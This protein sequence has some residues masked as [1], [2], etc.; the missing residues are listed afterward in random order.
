MKKDLNRQYAL[1]EVGSWTFD[2]GRS[3]VSILAPFDRTIA[4][5]LLCGWSWVRAIRGVT[6]VIAGLLLLLAAHPV[7]AAGMEL[8]IQTPDAELM[9]PPV[10]PLQARQEG[11]PLSWE[12]SFVK[13]FIGYLERGANKEALAY[14]REKEGTAKG[15]SFLDF[16]GLGDPGGQLKRRATAGGVDK[17]VR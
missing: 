7:C 5:H 12:D 2:V 11:L 1:F 3:L 15:F 16:I 6:T 9:M 10:A 17:W 13:D 4:N 8:R 14:F